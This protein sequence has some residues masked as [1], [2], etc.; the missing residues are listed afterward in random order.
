MGTFN[1]W[2]T[3]V[4]A[5]GKLDAAARDAPLSFAILHPL[6]RQYLM[7]ANNTV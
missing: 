6:N 5:R 1:W 4:I 7:L 2:E 3:S